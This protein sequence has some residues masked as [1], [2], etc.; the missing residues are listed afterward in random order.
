MND[1]SPDSQERIR[2]IYRLLKFYL[3]MSKQCLKEDRTDL[4][5]VEIRKENWRTVIEE[6]V[7]ALNHECDVRED[8]ATRKV[9]HDLRGGA[10]AGLMLQ[11]DLVYMLNTEIERTDVLNIFNLTRD[12]LKIMRNCIH[13]LDPEKRQLD[14]TVNEHSTSLLEEK[15]GNYKFEGKTIQYVSRAHWKIASCCLEFSTVDRVV[16]NLCNNALKYTSG[17]VVELHVNAVEE[18]DPKNIRILTYNEISS[19]QEASLR[20]QFQDKPSQLF[21]GGYTNSQGKGIGMSIC[22]ECVSNANGIN[23]QTK[24]IEHGYVGA[25]ILEG[26]FAVWV[27]WPLIGIN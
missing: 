2:N 17:N 26:G 8:S 16:Y 22:L 5:L 23:S 13:D 11:L 4:A 21:Y 12:H 1:F 25:A 9:A 15:W 14:L 27:H 3:S 6:F 7:A 20:K 10:L 18:K 19:E 24:S